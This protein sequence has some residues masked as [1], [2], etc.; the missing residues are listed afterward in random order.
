MSCQGDG[1]I[2]VEMLINVSFNNLSGPPAVAG[3][4]SLGPY[5]AIIE[6]R[7]Y[8]IPIKLTIEAD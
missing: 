5:A 3:G 7:P 2:L 1:E 8:D 6:G 4:Q